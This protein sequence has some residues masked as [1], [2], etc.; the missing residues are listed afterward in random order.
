MWGSCYCQKLDSAPKSITVN[1]LSFV[2]CISLTS[3]DHLLAILFL[4]AP[5]SGHLCWPWL[6]LAFFV[7][8]NILLVLAIVLHPIRTIYWDPV[9]CSFNQICIIVAYITDYS[10]PL[11]SEVVYSSNPASIGPSSYQLSLKFHQR[12]LS[13]VLLSSSRQF[14]SW[15]IT[16]NCNSYISVT[17]CPSPDANAHHSTHS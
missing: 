8:T 16:N 12:G 9:I 10:R 14:S 6:R 11:L 2:N 4:L 7:P 1:L 5:N 15:C 3:R 13:S 17:L